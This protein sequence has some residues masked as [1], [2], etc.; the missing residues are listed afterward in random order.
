MLGKPLA[1][2]DKT[3]SDSSERENRALKICQSH[4]GV[5]VLNAPLLWI[6]I[7]PDCTII[8]WE[9]TDGDTHVSS[10]DSSI[11]KPVCQENSI[12]NR[13][14]FRTSSLNILVLLLF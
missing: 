2:K 9:R 6:I 3:T 12:P 13:V 1:Q 4:C 10:P 11:L 14:F 7:C 5:E 8:S